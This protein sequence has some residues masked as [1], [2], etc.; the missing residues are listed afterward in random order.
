MWPSAP[1]PPRKKP[2]PPSARMRF[3][4]WPHLAGEEWE[5]EVTTSLPLTRCY[6]KG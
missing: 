3:S 4:N 5:G 1:M 6:Y 2:M